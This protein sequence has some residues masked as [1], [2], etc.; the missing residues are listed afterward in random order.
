MGNQG[1]NSLTK[2]TPKWWERS[3]LSAVL[4]NFVL[5]TDEERKQFFVWYNE[6]FKESK[7][8]NG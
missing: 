4:S 8:T 1:L 6:T 3:N 5:L 7:N 2:P